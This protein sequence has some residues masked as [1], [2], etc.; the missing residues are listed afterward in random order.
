PR[1]AV[2]MGLL[3]ERHS[4]SADVGKLDSQSWG[5][6]ELAQALEVEGET[7]KHYMREINK[8]LK[9][10]ARGR[11]KTIGDIVQVM[12]SSTSHEKRVVINV[13]KVTVGGN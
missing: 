7:I 13:D 2:M 4:E 3:A 6:R 12:R 10:E 11:E 5:V 9:Q 1:F 8:L